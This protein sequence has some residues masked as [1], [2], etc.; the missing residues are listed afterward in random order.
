MRHPFARSSRP[1][2]SVAAGKR[3][4]AAAALAGALALGLALAPL[5]RTAHAAPD[6]ARTLQV[7]AAASLS[8]A[9]TELGHRLEQSHPGLTVRMNFAGSQ[10]L[11]IQIEQ[12][13]AADVF[14]SADERWMAFANEHGLLDGEPVNFAR[15]QLV[16]IVPRTNPAR[17]QRLQDLGRRGIKLVL[18]AD[19]VPAGRYSRIALENL[20]RDPAF[21]ADFASRTLG[22]VVSDEENVKS[23]VGKVQLGEADAGIVYRSDVGAAL[24]RFV[25]V[26]E[27]PEGAN[28]LA[29]YPIALLKD[30]KPPE[31]ARAFVE[32]V[33]SPEGQRVLQRH[34]LLP[35]AG[36]TP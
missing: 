15:N 9:F 24:T 33:L 6:A 5:P 19:A 16:V 8:D 29:S 27:I 22:N 12:G 11:A 2:P 17:I 26:L 25:T 28:V 7:F 30:A 4:P 23:V 36:V 1:W 13:A 10:Q 21:G 20:S 35:A 3:R 32:L 31:A 14:A 34:G 18:A